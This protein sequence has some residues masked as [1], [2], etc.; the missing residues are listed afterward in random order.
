MKTKWI[1]IALGV[2]L[3]LNVAA[4]GYLL[5]S[6]SGGA[7]KW[8]GPGLDPTMGIGRLLRMVPEERRA[9]TVARETRRDIRASLLEVRRA[10]RAIDAA[11]AKEPFDSEQLRAALAQFRERFAASQAHSHAALV[12]IAAGL[13]PQERQRFLKAVRRK[14]REAGPR[15]PRRDA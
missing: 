7:S 13:T 4:V 9:D 10:Q 2:S 11:L 14:G 6:A 1:V 12:D 8:R 5:G 3:V 15:L